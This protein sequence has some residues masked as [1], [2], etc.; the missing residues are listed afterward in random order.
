VPAAF[1]L[2]GQQVGFD[3]GTY[4][5]AYV[6]T[7]D[8]SLMWNTFLGGS[9][10]DDEGN[11]IAMDGSGNIY[12]TGYS[13]AA[14]GT[15]VRVFGGGSYDAFVA[16][17]NSSGVLFW[18]T[19]LGGGGGND[20]GYGIAVDGS[21]NV[22]VTGSSNATWGSPLHAFAGSVDAFVAR[23]NSNGILTGIPSWVAVRMI[24]VMASPWMAAGMSM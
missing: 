7:I 4:D 17:L 9:G 19:F 6:L 12:V 22:Y 1:K 5:P 15:P 20:Y 18:S 16:R 13:N 2:D 14:W 3:L 10:G 8:P 23:L 11:A 21:G 24:M